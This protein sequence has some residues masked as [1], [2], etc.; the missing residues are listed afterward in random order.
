MPDADLD[1]ESADRSASRD[2][3]AL[4][5]LLAGT[6]LASLMSGLLLSPSNRSLEPNECRGFKGASELT[7]MLDWNR[8]MRSLADFP[9]FSSGR[10]LWMYSCVSCCLGVYVWYCVCA[11]HGSQSHTGWLVLHSRS[12]LSVHCSVLKTLRY[13][14]AVL[15][16]LQNVQTSSAVG[17]VHDSDRMIEQISMHSSIRASCFS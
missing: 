16:L 13:R 14:C 1:S 5:I 10:G 12:S 2:A 8:A 4:L 3:L 17:H 9:L 7:L 11:L 15:L 6:R